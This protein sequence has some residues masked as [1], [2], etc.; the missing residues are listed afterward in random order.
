[1]TAGANQ[2]P[3]LS[4]GLGAALAVFGFSG[5]ASDRLIEVGSR[6]LINIKSI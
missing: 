1:M 5:F 4:F 3:T 6:E 2:Y